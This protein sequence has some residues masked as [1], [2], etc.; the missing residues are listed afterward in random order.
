[1]AFDLDKSKMLSGAWAS[2]QQVLLRGRALGTSIRDNAAG[3]W[4]KVAAVLVRL[5]VGLLVSM[6]MVEI[7][8]NPK[9][10]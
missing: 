1:M 4:P 9:T 7:A 10:V 8:I 5:L 3:T 6:V 2:A